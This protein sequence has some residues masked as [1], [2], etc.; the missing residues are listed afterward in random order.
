MMA[1]PCYSG[2]KSWLIKPNL[3][4]NFQEIEI[5]ALGLTS[6]STDLRER[7]C[8]LH[9][10]TLEMNSTEKP[11]NLAVPVSGQDPGSHS[12]LEG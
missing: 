12:T 2:Y 4:K 3:S 9:N 7:K 10:V 6:G 1:L 5:I 8:C 11:W